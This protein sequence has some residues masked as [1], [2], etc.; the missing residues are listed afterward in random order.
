MSLKYKSWMDY[1]WQFK[2]NVH[3]IDPLTVVHDPSDNTVMKPLYELLGMK[4]SEAI[5]VSAPWRLNQLRKMRDAL[6]SETDWWVLPD[7]APT[8]AQLAYRQALR[9]IT[10][11][12]DPEA[13]IT[14]PVKP[15]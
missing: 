14:W 2:D 7:R 12:F 13:E 5:E 9:D 1:T 3:Q 8:E 10:N 6:I 4:K 15:E 11:D